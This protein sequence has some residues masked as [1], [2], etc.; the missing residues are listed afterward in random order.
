VVSSAF[1]P[2]AR[3]APDGGSHDGDGVVVEH[4][5]HVFRGKLVGGVADQE[6]RLADRTVADDDAPEEVHVSA[7]LFECGIQCKERQRTLLL[8]PPWWVVCSVEDV[9]GV[10]RR[11]S[12]S[13][14]SRLLFEVCKRAW[15]QGRVRAIEFRDGAVALELWLAV[16]NEGSGGGARLEH[17]QSVLRVLLP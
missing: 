8:R 7:L 3:R 15:A 4:G 11:I 9:K 6:T 1:S 2:R 13:R 12:R 17:G 14:N 16:Q 10:V 5:G